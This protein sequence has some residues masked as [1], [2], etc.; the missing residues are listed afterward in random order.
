MSEG[1]RILGQAEA[2]DGYVGLC[3]ACHM[4]RAARAGN[5]YKPF[6][7]SHYDS[8][9]LR[10]EA[11]KIEILNGAD[12]IVLHSSAENGFPHTRPNAV[13]CMPSDFITGS[14]N[15]ELAETLRHEAMH[16]HQR[17]FPELWREKCLREGWTPLAK[18]RIP[19]RFRQ[20]CR[21]NPDTFYDTPFWAWD[22]YHVPLPMFRDNSTPRDLGDVNIE[23]F[24]MRTGSLFHHPPRSFVERYGTPSQPEHPYE[25]LAVEYARTGITTYDQVYTKLVL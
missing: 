11:S 21:L 24:D 18:D 19:V 16:I 1:Q 22:K 7:V 6:F 13:V 23:W 20:H 3:S 15:T 4:N 8:Q 10:M 12:I 5:L 14:S 2:I 9:R 17:R 25:L